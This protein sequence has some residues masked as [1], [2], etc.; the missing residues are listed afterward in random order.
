MKNMPARGWGMEIVPA[1]GVWDS[2]KLGPA[3]GDLLKLNSIRMLY[4]VMS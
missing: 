3:G 4:T 1:K 2:E